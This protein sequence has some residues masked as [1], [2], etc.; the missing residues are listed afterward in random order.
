MNKIPCLGL[1]FL[2]RCSEFHLREHFLFN[3]EVAVAS[4]AIVVSIYALL[5]ERRFRVR[6]SIKKDERDFILKLVALVLGLTF[7]GAILPFIPGEPLP[8]GGYP[9]F[10]E[11]LASVAILY[12]FYL[13]YRIILPIRFLT[14][15][16]LKRLLNVVPQATKKY[17]GSMDLMLKEADLFWDDF[18]KKAKEDSNLQILLLRDFLNPEFVKLAVT[19]HYLLVKTYR[20]TGEHGGN[21]N[22]NSFFRKLFIHHLI[23]DNSIVAEDLE[24]S[25]KPITQEIIRKYRLANILFKNNGDLFSLRLAEYKNWANIYRRFS[26]LFKLYLG[27]T[28][29][30]SED[31][32]D[33]IG[34]IDPRVIEIFL[35]FFKENLTHLTEDE[36]DEFMSWFAFHVPQEIIRKLPETESK[37][38]ANGIY[39]LLEQYAAFRDWQK[40]DE[41][42]KDYYMLIEFKMNFI[43]ENKVIKET[44]Q[45][46]LT[47]K[48][49]GTEDEEKIER[50]VYNLKGFYPMVLPIYFHMYG[51]E[52]FSK[53]E[54]KEEKEMHMKILGKMKKNLPILSQGITQHYMGDKKMP[55]DEKGKEAVK[56]KAEKALRAMF[57][58]DVYY[59]KEENSITRTTGDGER[60]VTLLLNETIEKGEFV[61]KNLPE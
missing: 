53:K 27:Q 17:H 23:E 36:K 40:E 26:I 39:E 12:A 35:K 33:Y 2:A 42:W 56:R 51:P 7:L 16:Q 59:D 14:K 54:P 3:F 13:S 46:R 52:L 49:A 57:P 5:I 38:L 41:G 11:A 29:R 10:W 61:Y 22:I 21:E 1:S 44:F 58:E 30:N 55:A 48:I 47:D 37:A 6:I 50:L 43:D 4:I 20:F 24:S 9:I 45:E 19:S 31:T 18:L 25:Y 15:K 34:L 8:L 60:S 32:K 28:Y